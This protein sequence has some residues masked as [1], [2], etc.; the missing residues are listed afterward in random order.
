MATNS[1]SFAKPLPYTDVL[2]QL[3][4]RDFEE[5]CIGSKIK[6]AVIYFQ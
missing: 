5:V 1:E 4:I 3:I 6:R 2:A